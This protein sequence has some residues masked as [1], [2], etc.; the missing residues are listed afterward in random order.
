MGLFRTV[1]NH[2]HQVA[3]A[4]AQQVDIHNAP[5]ADQARLL[6]DLEQEAIG[7]ITKRSILENSL[8]HASMTVI[9]EPVTQGQRVFVSMSLNGEDVSF[10]FLLERGLEVDPN[11]AMRRAHKNLSEHI[12]VRL[13]TK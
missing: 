6:H 9:E 10:D 1:H 12:A 8:A 11:A 2:N 7:R 13:M 4:Y 3:P 5:A